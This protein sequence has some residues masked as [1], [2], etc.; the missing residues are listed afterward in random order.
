MEE[1]LADNQEELL[2]ADQAEEEVSQPDDDEVIIQVG[3]EEA[4][5]SEQEKVEE[6]PEWVKELRRTN[7][8]DKKR[9]RELELKLNGTQQQPKT[10]L[11]PKPTLESC[12]F[13]SER[14]EKALD[15]WYGIK[16]VHEK[17]LAKVEEESTKQQQEYNNKVN[18]YNEA[19]AKLKVKNFDDLEED[20]VKHLSVVQQGIL[21]QGAKNPAVLVAA[22]GANNGKL[23]AELATIQD[24]IKFAFA[25]AELE[26]KLKVTSRKA[27]PPETTFKSGAPTSA[28]Q[29]LHLKKLEEEADRTGDRT[30]VIQYKRS[31][32][33]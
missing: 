33:K 10:V 4:P 25:A 19:K 28:T 29:D 24:P 15:D 17:E 7:R 26:T 30:K 23:A 16:S 12:D 27:P 2:Q 1:N 9:I 22:L 13:D 8:E 31:L 18:T 14:L 5:A 11:P 20:T 32:K 6:A 3:D 21:I